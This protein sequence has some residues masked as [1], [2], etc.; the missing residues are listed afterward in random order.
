ML[1]STSPGAKL[2]LAC[3]LYVQTGTPLA[4]CFVEQISRWANSSL[5]LANLREPNST[6]MLANGWGPRQTAGKEKPSSLMR[7]MEEGWGDR[8]QLLPI[9]SHAVGTQAALT[10]SRGL[11]SW[12]TRPSSEQGSLLV[13]FCPYPTP[14]D[15]HTTPHTH[16]HTQKGALQNPSRGSPAD[17]GPC[18]IPRCVS[19][20]LCSHQPLTLFNAKC[21]RSPKC[22]FL[23]ISLKAIT[24]CN[25][26]I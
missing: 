22:G 19:T 14:R 3:T 17:F 1:P 4:P 24:V 11:S 9:R 13:L 16:T 10:C 15:R 5:E 21:S 20:E 12:E 8:S 6:A 7:L 25:K 26:C 23:G 2:E 18:N